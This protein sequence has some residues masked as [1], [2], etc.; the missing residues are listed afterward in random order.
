[1]KKGIISMMVIA[2]M[3]AC[4]NQETIESVPVLTEQST[5]NNNIRSYEDALKIAQSSIAMLESSKA[6]SRGISTGRKIDLNKSKVVTLDNKTR[7]DAGIK[8]TLI[9]V[10]NFEN[11][12][13]FSLISASKNTVP[14]LAVTEKGHC[15]VDKPS[16]VEGFNLF[17]NMAKQYVSRSYDR[18]E[19]DTTELIYEEIY[20]FI[21]RTYTGPYLEVT[22][23]DKYPDAE[24]IS[25]NYCGCVPTAIAQVFSYYGIPS[26]MNLTYVGRDKTSQTFNWNAMKQHRIGYNIA[27]CNTDDHPCDTAVHKSISRLF[28]QIRE[29]LNLNA[30]NSISSSI[31][32]FSDNVRY[33][34][35][36]KV[37]NEDIKP[38]SNV[39]IDSLLNNGHIMILQ[40]WIEPFNAHAWVLDGYLKAT[41]RTYEY[42]HHAGDPNWTLEFIS[43]SPNQEEFCHY[44]WG[45]GG[46]CNGYYS[47]NVF[48]VSECDIPDIAPNT[49]PYYF[50]NVEVLVPY[51]DDV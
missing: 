12:E 7:S 24:L 21:N 25:L 32:Y 17:M 51:P 11:N 42:T 46:N 27:S 1:M 45:W 23:G 14:I 4:T 37:N 41:R 9:Y 34:G 33:H 22:W 15:D 19:I 31:Y 6:S 3:T 16:E 49:N 39:N 2:L 30:N 5:V 38:F 50:Y 47:Y 18:G 36:K 35:Y 44:N 28:M 26:T 13:G 43:D 20:E 29:D 8:D 48:D 40:G 10:F